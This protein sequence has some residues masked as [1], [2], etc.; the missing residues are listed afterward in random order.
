MPQARTIVARDGVAGLFG[1]GLRTR[2]VINGVQSS[3]FGVFWKAL[4]QRMA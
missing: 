4:Q 2:L 1:R 3:I